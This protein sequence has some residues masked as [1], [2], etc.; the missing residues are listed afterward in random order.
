MT[1]MMKTMKSGTPSGPSLT[2]T[3]DS[4]ENVLTGTDPPQ[5]TGGGDRFSAF[6]VNNLTIRE[7]L[8]GINL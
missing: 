6:I 2:A 3:V 1:G 7:H 4:L 5:R 8:S